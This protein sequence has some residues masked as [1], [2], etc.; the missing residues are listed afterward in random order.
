[1]KEDGKSGSCS[2]HGDM[3]NGHNILVGTL[4]ARDKF[5][6]LDER[7]ILIWIFRYRI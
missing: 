1:M 5:G 4:R 6:I 7:V 3:K 2:V